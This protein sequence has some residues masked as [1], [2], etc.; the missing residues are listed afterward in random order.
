MKTS[1]LR[2]EVLKEIWF[3]AAQTSNIY[4]KRRILCGHEINCPS[5][6]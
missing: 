6:E 4:I 1:N 3:I 2:K 5:P